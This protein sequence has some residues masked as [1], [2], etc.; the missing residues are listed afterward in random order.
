[1][2]IGTT[3]VAINRGSAALTLAGITLTTPDIGT[4]SAGVLT[5]CTGLP[6]AS[7]V[8]GSLVAAMEASDHGTAATD[9]LVNVCYGTGA[10]PDASTTTEGSLYITYTA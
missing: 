6:A 7:V 1:M 2:Y 5:N 3:G 9:Q 4:P 8:A 10:A